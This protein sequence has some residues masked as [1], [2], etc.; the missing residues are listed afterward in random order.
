MPPV[1]ASA[2]AAS[3]SPGFLLAV[4][5]VL[6]L[7]PVI[8]G[9][10]VP[11]LPAIRA[12]FGSSVTAVQLTVSLSMLVSVLGAAVAGAWSDRVGRRPVVLGSVALFLAGMAACVWAPNIGVLVLGRVLAGAS[13]TC[14]LVVGRA[15]VADAFD[16]ASAPM[17][18]ATVHVA[19]L[20]AFALAP[21]VGGELTDRFGW[22]STFW[23]LAALGAVVAV[24]AWAWL[25]ETRGEAARTP[26]AADR[27]RSLG[28]GWA[29]PNLP[30]FV[31]FVLLGAL[32]FGASFGFL[33]AGAHLVID[34]VGASSTTFGVGFLVVNLAV[35]VG[36][37]GARVLLPRLGAESTVLVG[38]VVAAA[39]GTGLWLALTSAPSALV[40]FA[41]GSAVGV[42]VGLA[43]PGATAGALSAFPGQSGA[44]SGISSLLQMLFAAAC[45]QLVG[46]AGSG[47]R[48]WYWIMLAA[49]L[50]AAVACSAVP[51]SRRARVA[52]GV[53]AA[54]SS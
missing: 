17:A 23:A 14:A 44:T 26:A 40:F 12:E 42:G 48:S 28:A 32:H 39:S 51:W 11:A 29:D 45:A 43:I 18:M 38:A 10:Y 19:P 13:T 9:A 30:S 15:A 27:R 1:R 4:A 21:V 25:P 24:L 8:I 6:S 47:A 52:I 33:T 54:P 7:G 53:R 41:G 22:R 50:W 37:L 20:A 36:T 34:G 35:L 31:G 3:P 5:G 49:L 2:S 46:V 16:R